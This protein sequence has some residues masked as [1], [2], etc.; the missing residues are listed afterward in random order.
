[1]TCSFHFLQFHGDAARDC[2]SAL[3]L[4]IRYQRIGYMH[5]CLSTICGAYDFR[6]E[7]M[8][9]FMQMRAQQTFLFQINI[10]DVSKL[11]F[12]VVYFTS[13][14]I[15]VFVPSIYGTILSWNSA[16]LTHSI[17]A[18]N[19]TDRDAKYK[20]AFTIFVER[21]FRPMAIYAGGLFLLSLPT[22]LSVTIVET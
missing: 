6:H 8:V 18:S 9:R 3:L 2:I 21:T 16:K 17:F 10:A 13:M 7:K 4:P 14:I 15:Q 19:W 22:F 12:T 5:M 1:M 11:A 20:R